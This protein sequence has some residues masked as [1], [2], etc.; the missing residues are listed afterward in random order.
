MPR[1]EFDATAFYAALDASRAARRLNWKQVAEQSG[2]SA[3]TLTRLA[4]KKRPDVDSLAALLAWSGLSADAYV[5]SGKERPKAEPLSQIA[6]YLSSD[7]SLS[8]TGRLALMQVISAA[9]VQ[10]KED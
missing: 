5:V 8:D 3:S 4:Q 2:V 1:A 7:P 10:F 9:Y 6:T